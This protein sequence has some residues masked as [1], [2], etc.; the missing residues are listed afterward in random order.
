VRD[1][2]SENRSE[3]PGYSALLL[4]EFD[5][6]FVWL[7]LG[8]L[9]APQ[10]PRKDVEVHMRHGLARRDTIL[11]RNRIESASKYQSQRR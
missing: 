10:A 6:N 2:V 3:V 7:R 8:E 11:R 5:V 1:S 9:I 4:L